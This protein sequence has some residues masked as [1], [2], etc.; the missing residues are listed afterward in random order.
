MAH[1]PNWA[2]IFPSIPTAFADD[3]SLDLE[4]QAAVARFS[5]ECGAQGLLCFGL[6][7]EV[8]RLTPQERIAALE[9]IVE[10][11]A[12]R[13]P[14]LAGVGTEALHSSLA[15][16]REA[17][18]AGADG[19][20]IPPPVSTRPSRGELI[21]YFAE[22]ATAGELP[23][24][25]QD[26]PVYL[27]IE[28]GPELV[29]EAA[30]LAP[31]IVCV[32]LEAG[33]ERIAEWIAETGDTF[34]IFDGNA[35]IA[36]LDT[37]DNGAVGNAP[38]ADVTDELVASYALWLEGDAEGARQRFAPLL[39]LL[40]FE[41]QGI[42]H[43]NACAKHLLWRRGVLASSH[44]RAPTSGLTAVG[45]ALAERYFDEVPAYKSLS[46]AADRAR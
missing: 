41:S 1:S 2:G 6:A 37:L 11:V 8:F 5:V 32:K 4:S 45:R 40:V 31:E 27:G 23:V 42:E 14:V 10:G 28:L 22:I 46:P 19:L 3:G 39:P 12:G 9:A 13:I 36:L 16:A 33:P 35:G 24:M 43:F 17:R 7:G 29:Q 18:A 15:L 34:A 25:V 38:G 21:R 26:A 20:V 30:R 44:M